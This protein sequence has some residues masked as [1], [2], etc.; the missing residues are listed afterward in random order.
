MCDI[1]PDLLKK[2]LLKP[3]RFDFYKPSSGF[4]NVHIYI[5]GEHVSGFAT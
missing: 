4:K 5:R 1:E 2:K 3:A